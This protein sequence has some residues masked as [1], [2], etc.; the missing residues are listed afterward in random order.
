MTTRSSRRAARPGDRSA[1]RRRPADRATPPGSRL[2]WLVALAGALLV[3]VA[4]VA[5]LTTRDSTVTAPVGER[6]VDPSVATLG[7]GAALPSFRATADD[8]AVGQAIPEVRGSSFAGTDVAIAADGRPKVL[9]F[10]AHWC[11]H[12]QREVPVVQA[13]LDAGRLDASV[14]L[15]SVATAIDPT[16]PNYPPDAWLEREHWSAPVLVDDNGTVAD[17]FGLSAFPYW[18]AV[19]REGKVVQRVTGELTPQQIEALVAAV[20]R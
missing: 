6:P 15:I 5:I 4:G 19:D 13:W 8:P 16:R 11:P 20:A 12:C 17:R 3:G 14:D 1:P 2:P 18:V 9:L 10:V 7:G